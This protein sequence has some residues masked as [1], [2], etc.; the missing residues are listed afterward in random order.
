METITKHKEND[1]EHI[2]IKRQGTA[3]YR[4]IPPVIVVCEDKLSEI[5]IRQ[6]EDLNVKIICAG[7]WNNFTTLLYGINFYRK[8]LNN[9]DGL[10]PEIV[11]VIDGDIS[12]NEIISR[13]ENTHNGRINGINDID[14]IKQKIKEDMVS[15]SL[16]YELDGNNK[17]IP[18]F[19]HKRWLDSISENTIREVLSSKLNAIDVEQEIKETL[20]IINASQKI[21]FDK[22]KDGYFDYHKYYNILARKLENGD[23]FHNYMIHYIEYTVISIIKNIIMKPG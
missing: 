16:D 8:Q 15:F 17:G 21:N 5:I 4:Y 1:Y 12:E 3:T 6:I 19:N 10:L 18:E 7:S 14:Y 13:I 2:E 11:C 23:T 22:K 20:R 9:I